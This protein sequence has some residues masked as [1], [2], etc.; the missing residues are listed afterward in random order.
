[1]HR[2]RIVV[3]AIT[4]FASA[5]APAQVTSIGLASVGAQRFGNHF[6]PTYPATIGDAYGS[7][8]AT[9]DFNGDGVDDLAVGMPEDDGA[10]GA[11]LEASGV[12]LL[13]YGI[14]GGGLSGALDLL[15]RGALAD[16]EVSDYF[17][18]ALA[19][20]D[21]DGDGVD[22]LAVGAPGESFGALAEAGAVFVFY[23]GTE[24]VQTLTQESPGIPDEIEALD[25][26]GSALACGDFNLDGRAD[27]AIGAMFETVGQNA[28]GGA[29][30]VV[31]GS[32]AGLATS[33]A[34]EL[35]QDSPEIDDAAEDGDRFGAALAAGDF[36]G[37]GFVDLAIGVPGEDFSRGALHVLFGS[38][39]GL[40][41]SR[42]IYRDESGIGGL[43]ENQD[44][45]ADALAVGDFDGDGA[46]DLAIGIPFE[47]FGAGNSILD[48]GQAN[49]LYGAATGFDFTRTQF[50]AQDNILGAGT[51]EAN[52][53]FGASFAAG[54]FDRDGRD[55][56]AIGGPRE[57]VTGADDGAVTVIVGSAGGLTASRRRGFAAG[58]EGVPGDADLHVKAFSFA[59]AAGDFD[60]D[61]HDDL[62]ISAPFE[63]EE[64]V[65]FAGSVT[66]L[67]G[68][69][70]ADGF[71]TGPDENL[72]SLL[73]P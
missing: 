41:A 57:F 65:V 58:F 14:P 50:W 64:G 35:H 72:W 63:D 10:V 53:R 66:I 39:V 22:D 34:V 37:D 59:L 26:F 9:G 42:E 62:A 47:D 56:L 19:A 25:T 30:F 68:S 45:F 5:A 70:F 46:D 44:R 52:D 73:V 8:F 49:V 3:A 20:C 67:H 21:F 11:E 55:D 69:L 15:W 17:G 28:Q 71:E 33:G 32:P 51:S 16:A 38:D 48:C 31:P 29:I 27:L 23:P 12:V 4:C 60:G 2:L 36:D 43:A 13:H 6:G 61:G 54:D 18:F 7:A 1:M 24:L 40:T